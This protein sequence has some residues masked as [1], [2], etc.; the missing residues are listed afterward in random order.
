MKV[1]ILQAFFKKQSPKIM[2]HGNYKNNNKS[3]FQEQLLDL[4]DKTC[5]SDIN[6]DAFQKNLSFSIKLLSS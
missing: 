6:I 4:L 3:Y 2:S 1:T 5:Q